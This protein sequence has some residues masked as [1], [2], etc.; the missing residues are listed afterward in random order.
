[1]AKLST[2]QIREQA[3]KII[4]NNNG[5][6]QYSDLHEQIAAISPETPKNTIHGSI[7]DLHLRFPQEISKPSRGLFVPGVAAPAKNEKGE[8]AATEIPKHK[9]E[10]FYEPFAEW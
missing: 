8:E 10:D 5:G 7:W 9:E 3:R 4:A 2:H 1:M 6:I